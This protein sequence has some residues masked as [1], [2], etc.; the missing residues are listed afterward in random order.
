M[1][2]KNGWFAINLGTGRGYSVL[3]VV[4]CF[5]KILKLKIK[6][7]YTEKRKGDLAASYADTTK[8]RKYLGW[9][10]RLNL[11]DMCKS[12]CLWKKLI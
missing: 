2:N 6:I 9:K 10:A 12:F 8:A 4:K 1:K 3:D 7:K 5:Q 11:Y